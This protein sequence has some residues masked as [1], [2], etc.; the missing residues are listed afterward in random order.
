MRTLILPAFL[1]SLLF[2]ACAASTPG[3]QPHDMSATAHES[4]A[5]EHRAEADSHSADFN[6]DAGFTTERCSRGNKN[7]DGVCWTAIQNPT[8]T[9]REEAEKHR[10]MAADHRAA[11]QALRDAEARACVGLADSDR[12]MSPFEHREDIMAVDPL[13]GGATTGKSAP[14]R[15]VGAT[16]TIRAVPGLTAEWLQRVI[17]CH[18][19]R[20]AA[21][22]HAVPEMP[23]CPLVPKGAS[24]KVSSAGTGFAVAIQSDDP[25]AAREILR[26]ATL[27]K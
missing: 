16:V 9:H 1:S 18:V 22:G 8:A 12:D 21:L 13:N 20:N 27:L 26:R 10:K 23:T 24:A 7:A 19:A 25:E 4:A 2:V 11:S 5:K 17:D 14:P 6:P 15:T 3:A